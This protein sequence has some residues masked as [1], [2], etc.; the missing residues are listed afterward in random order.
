MLKKRKFEL[1]NYLKHQNSTRSKINMNRHIA[2][3]KR[4]GNSYTQMDGNNE[5]INKYSMQLTLEIIESN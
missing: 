2:D 4:H 5:A 3:E 1:I